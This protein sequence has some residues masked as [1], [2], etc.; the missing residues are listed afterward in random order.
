VTVLHKTGEAT[1]INL[2]KLLEEGDMTQNVEL[3]PGDVLV[4][5]E[6]KRIA[7][8]G[9]VTTPSSFVA[10]KPMPLLSA[11][12]AGGAVLPDADLE[13]AKIVGPDGSRDVNIKAL[14][15][16]GAGAADLQI[17]PGE[18]LVIPEATP[19][20]VLLAGA[21]THPGPVDI[22]NLKERSILRLI[23]SVGLTPAGDPTRI[24]ILRGDKQLTVDY[25]AILKDA[26]LD[27]NINIEPGDI[28]YVP[29]LQK[30]Y[31]IGAVASGGAALPCQ[32]QGMKILDA[33]VMSGGLGP[34]ADPNQIHV[35]RP[36]PDGTTEH[37]Q[38]RMG[39]VQKG[40]LPTMITLK[41]GDIVF[42]GIKGQPFSWQSFAQILWTLSSV[43]TLLG[44]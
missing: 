3:K 12:A 14:K 30:V 40:K 2:Q 41:P 7:I 43:R 15:E 8:V 22:H 10:N 16:T 31:V 5:R 34:N 26:A 24:V 23:T 25:Q 18:T 17:G 11:L 37:M 13:H 28:I 1:Q 9:Q 36:R 4:V 19:Q 27:Q 33:L 29:D 32:D 42:V 6:A 44:H 35:V 39:D 20:E 21:V 38:L